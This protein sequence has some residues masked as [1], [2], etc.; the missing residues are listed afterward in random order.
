MALLIELKGGGNTPWVANQASGLF[1][2]LDF[3]SLARAATDM[4]GV[5]LDFVNMKIF[6]DSVFTHSAV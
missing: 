4:N 1:A 5:V 3:D 6:L 2:N